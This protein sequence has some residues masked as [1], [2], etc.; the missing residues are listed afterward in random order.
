VNQLANLAFLVAVATFGAASLLE[1]APVLR[2][3]ATFFTLGGLIGGAVVYRAERRGRE[4]TA[5]QVRQILSRWAFGG[6]IAGSSPSY[7]DWYESRT[8]LAALVGVAL[9][10]PVVAIAEAI[11]FGSL[12]WVAAIMAV[13][14]VVSLVDREGFYGPRPRA[15]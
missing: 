11:R 4:L 14:V 2:D 9:L 1:D 5:L 15:R 10:V 7:Y 12:A 3:V 8:L 13:L 6:A